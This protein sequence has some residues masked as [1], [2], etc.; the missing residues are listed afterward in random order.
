ML[1]NLWKKSGFPS[2]LLYPVLWK[3][4][5]CSRYSIYDGKDDVAGTQ[6]TG[7][8]KVRISVDELHENKSV[9]NTVF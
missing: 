8:K 7:I 1:L 4:F 5:L 9:V 3:C 6:H 2:N